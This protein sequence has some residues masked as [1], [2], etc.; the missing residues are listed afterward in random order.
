MTVLTPGHLLE[1]SQAIP[2]RRLMGLVR[3]L[4]RRPD[5][6]LTMERVREGLLDRN[7]TSKPWGPMT[8]A[9]K[10]LKGLGWTWRDNWTVRRKG[11]D[12]DLATIDSG[13]WGHLIRDALRDGQWRAAQRRTDMGG[14]ATGVD[15]E[16]RRHERRLVKRAGWVPGR[17]YARG[18]GGVHY[19][20]GPP[21]PEWPSG[22][23]H[24]PAL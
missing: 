1:P 13:K 14:L 18:P 24:L 6:R 2:Y 5:L 10:A 3:M 11:V 4:Q 9:T 21:A 23:W 17:Y 20:P 15:K 12:T 22:E 19:D 16:R 8:L 7:G